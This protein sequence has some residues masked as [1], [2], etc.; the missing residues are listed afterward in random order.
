MNVFISYAR[1]DRERARMLA[2]ALEAAGWSVWWDTRIR[3]GQ[4]FDEVIERELETADSVVVLWS[5]QSIVSEWVKNEASA[6][7]DRGVLVPARIDDIKPPLAFRR[8]QTADLV[9]WTGDPSHA[10]FHALRDAIAALAGSPAAASPAPR[11]VHREPPS[12]GN[13]GRLLGGIALGVAVLAFGAYLWPRMSSPEAPT[14]DPE[15]PAVPAASPEGPQKSGGSPG[16]FEFKW[17]GRDCWKIYRGE[18][19]AASDCGSGRLALQ[20]G[21]Y[22]VKPS[23]SAVFVPFSVTVK[24]GATTTADA[25]AG[26]F[27]FKWPGGDC[28]KI[29]R[30]EKEAANDC[31]GGKHALQAGTY[32][33]KPSHSAVFV[34]FS[35]TVR[36]GSTTTSDAQGGTFDFK[37]PGRD[38]WKI[39]RGETEAMSSCGGGKHALQEGVYVLKPSY[40]AVFEPLKVRVLR[41]QT[42]SAP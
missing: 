15:A 37:W 16:I 41:G 29:Y 14:R 36:A 26:I 11:A 42:A 22:L 3:A 17:P 5:R 31:G 38:C 30:G 40:S 21:T 20:A 6:A 33:V 4:T 2:R 28:W 25:D 9:G 19:E 18:K 27:E 1:D 24:A 35:L 10:G 34:P 39:Y 12:A 32:L 7:L 23:H 13:R 8:R